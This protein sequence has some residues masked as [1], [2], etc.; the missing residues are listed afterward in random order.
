MKN[1]FLFKIVFSVVI[2]LC[3]T[4]IVSA[5]ELECYYMNDNNV[6]FSKEEYEFLSLMYW[7][8]CQ[9]LLTKDD[10]ILFKNSEI[11]NSDFES[12]T[13]SPNMSKSTSIS[14]GYK[15]LKISKAC[16]SECTISVTTTW[17][18]SPLIKGYDVMG[19]YLD[20]VSLTNN[21]KTL[22]Y[23]SSSNYSSNEI[24]KETY[25]FGVSF[26]LPSIGMNTTINQTFK[27]SKNGKIYAS[28]QHA[29]KNISLSDSKN[30]SF[31]KYGYG[32]VF[33]FKGTALNTYDRMNGVEIDV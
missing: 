19:A 23:N 2:S 17:G 3:L 1:Q 4:T 8:G 14:D 22:I 25:A 5:D 6:C 18:S 20:G 9:E 11:M 15:T 16:L 13:Y 29:Q 30:Y 10:Y 12:V 24:K 33:D 26:T 21:P 27:T 28:Y 31:S 32:R 7:D